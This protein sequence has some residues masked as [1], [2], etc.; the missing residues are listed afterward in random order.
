MQRSLRL[1]VR[2]LSTTTGAQLESGKVYDSVSNYYGKVLSS[3]KD[4]KTSAC[5]TSAKPAQ[6]ILDALKLVPDPIK[7][8]YYGCGT[9]LPDGIDGLDLLDLGSGSGRDC[10]VAASLVGANGSVTGVDMTD[11]QLGIANQHVSEYM[12]KLGYKEENLEF[13]KGYIEFLQDAGV[14]KESVD[15]VISNCVINLSPNKELV[16]KGVFDALREGGEL[17]FSDVYCDRRLPEHVRTHDVMLGECLGG[18]LYIED[19]IRIC[20]NVGFTDPR[21][22]SIDPITVTD[23]ELQ[24]LC[25]NA[26]FFSITYRCFKLSN[27]ETLCEDYGQVGYYKGTIPNHPNSYELDDH[28]VFETNKP[29]LVCGNTASMVGETWLGKHF[30][31]VGDRSTHFGLFDC[32]PLPEA[33]GS[34]EQASAG[35]GCC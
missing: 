27:L 11:E 2:R 29:M 3:S 1:A 12:S 22:L 4:L 15:M 21:R 23:P 8:R 34:T 32:A 14:E 28:H 30:E 26:R 35:G 7:D 19:F 18:A 25:G 10:Y 20:R 16:L 17:Y 13:K 6:N 33:G 9:P 5:T 24:E 31:I